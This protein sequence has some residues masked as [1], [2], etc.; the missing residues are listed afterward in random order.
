MQLPQLA[1]GVVKDAAGVVGGLF[2]RRK[3]DIS[4][5]KFSLL[6]LLGLEVEFK[7]CQEAS[8]QINGQLSLGQVQTFEVR[9]LLI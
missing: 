8:G 7:L 2:G 1:G 5:R 9:Y 3:R 6:E 4:V